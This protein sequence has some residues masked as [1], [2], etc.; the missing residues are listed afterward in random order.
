MKYIVRIARSFL[1]AA[2]LLT[3][4]AGV[5]SA[6]VTPVQG[7]SNSFEQP[8]PVTPA[9]KEIQRL[10]KQISSNAAIAGKHGENLES[11]A[12][13]GSR[14]QYETHAVELMRAK[15]AIN[16][17]GSDFAQLQELRPG[18]L[19]WQQSVIDRM[20]PVLVALAGDATLA[21]DRLNHDRRQL[22]SQAYRDAV[23]N[24]TDSAG[25]VRDL[26]SVNL[27]YAEARAKLDRL[28]AFTL[29]P[30]PKLSLA[31]D[32]AR[33]SPKA[34]KNLEQRVQSELL[35]LPYYGV[36]DHL[37]FQVEGDQVKLS[38]EVT[39]PALKSD[40]E[41]AVRRVEGVAAV[42]SDIKVLPPSFHDDRIRRATYWAVYGNS[43]LARYRLNPNPPIRIIV[44]NGNVTLKG[45]VA[46]ELDKTIAF[47]RASGVPGVFSVTDH[48]QV[49]S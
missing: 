40:A 45:F 8:M 25:E 10:L 39:R 33:V 6:T 7:S 18:A 15:D 3:Q 46:N 28:D 13:V 43:A 4:L 17:M 37:A 32:A 1:G 30:V 36:F 42:T 22:P 11:F 29:E 44:A 35:K 12:R 26:I 49:G 2:V 19:P 14:L 27:D 5:S 16:A 48:L 47:M 38:G 31:P 9:Q 24:L 20:E 21:I 41:N 34:A 23:G